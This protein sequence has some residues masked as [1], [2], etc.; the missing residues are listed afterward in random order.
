MSGIVQSL[1]I[2]TG[3]RES[4]VHRVMATAPVRY[5]TYTIPK[6]NGE[7][8]LISQPAREVKLLQRALVEVLLK[9]LPVH[10]C[11]TAYRTGSSI[12][13]NARPHAGHRPIIK[14]DLKEFFPSIKG[15]DWIAYC[16][17]TG[18]LQDQRDVELTTHLLFQRR[19]GSHLLQLA[20][21]APSSPMVSNLLMY[22]F[23]KQI[24][25]A[26]SQ[27]LDATSQGKVAY[28]RYA[29]DM[30]FSAPR[31]GYL[32][33]VVKAVAKVIRGLEY[34]KLE[35]NAEK[36]TYITT[37]YHRTVTGLTLTNDG[38]V[39]IGRD[40]KRRL[41]AAV[42]QALFIKVSSD[43]L[44]SLAGMLAYV[45][46]VEPDFLTVLRRKYGGEAISRIQRAGSIGDQTSE[47]EP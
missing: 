30:T 46:S 23:D 27:D 34:P 39:T 29:D 38:R 2:A 26:V 7:R 11:A 36:T 40:Q 15:R 45:N 22:E 31:T 9:S 35:I 37:K 14:M 10:P 4:L 41:H 44:T 8:R 13:D 21:G 17:E 42:H 32:T 47:I 3:L 5:K 33:G 25:A 1:S 16:K 24:V 43:D 18:C 12:V 20:I 6:R 19:N 28:T